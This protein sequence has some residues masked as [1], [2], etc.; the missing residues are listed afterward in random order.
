MRGF[1]VERIPSCEDVPKRSYEWLSREV[2]STESMVWELVWLKEGSYEAFRGVEGRT[3]PSTET[4]CLFHY[5][6]GTNNC[7]ETRALDRK[8]TSIREDYARNNTILDSDKKQTSLF[9]QHWNRC[10]LEECA[11]TMQ[12]ALRCFYFTTAGH[13][14]E[15][16][17]Y[18][19][20]DKRQD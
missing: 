3:E 5:P 10:R 18:G 12:W 19:G 6:C 13:E 15:P 7:L 9:C 4:L 2:E 20:P 8:G 14:L 11:E 1:C 16:T 17:R